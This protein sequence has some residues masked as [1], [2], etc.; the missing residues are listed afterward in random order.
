MQASCRYPQQ[1]REQQAPPGTITL[2]NLVKILTNLYTHQGQPRGRESGRGGGVTATQMHNLKLKIAP[3]QVR[4]FCSSA[5]EM[6]FDEVNNHMC[7][8]EPP[9]SG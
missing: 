9:L 6:L 8:L 3:E 4:V 1:P 7:A 2:R 5:C